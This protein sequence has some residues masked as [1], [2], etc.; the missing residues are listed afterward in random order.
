MGHE[1]LEIA[2][3]GERAKELSRRIDELKAVNWDRGAHW[4]GIAGKLNPKGSFSVGGS[5]ETA[6]AIYTALTDPASAGYKRV[7]RTAAVA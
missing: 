2:D 6:Y 3:A 7:H 5:K 1:L 4:E